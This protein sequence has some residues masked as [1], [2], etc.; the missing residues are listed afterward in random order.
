MDAIT[1]FCL[2]LRVFC[3]LTYVYI[4]D[5]QILR[6]RRTLGKR[7]VGGEKEHSFERSKEE[8]RG[9][10]ISAKSV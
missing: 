5:S 10:S 9:R 2:I 4:T 6:R 1:F 3:E 8:E 7:Q